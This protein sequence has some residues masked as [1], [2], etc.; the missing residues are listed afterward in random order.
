MVVRSLAGKKAGGFALE[1]GK[2]ASFTAD[3]DLAVIGPELKKHLDE[4]EA[5]GRR[6]E[7]FTFSEKKQAICLQGLEDRILPVPEGRSADRSN[8][9]AAYPLSGGS[10]PPVTSFERSA[11]RP[12]RANQRPGVKTP[13]AVFKSMSGRQ[14]GLPTL[15]LASD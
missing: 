6:D 5:A 9:V 15:S 12:R 1:P 10:P 3:F 14:S 7:K 2:P 8:T 4:D 11:D 13:G